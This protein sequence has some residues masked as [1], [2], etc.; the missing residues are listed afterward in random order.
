MRIGPEQVAQLRAEGAALDA[1]E[2][3]VADHM[4][5][6]GFS[7]NE[8]VEAYRAYREL[9]VR[10]PEIAGYPL[11]GIETTAIALRLRLRVGARHE[12]LAAH[13]DE[14]LPVTEAYNERV[15]GGPRVVT[16]G[17]VLLVSGLVMIPAGTGIIFWGNGIDCSSSG[18]CRTRADWALIPGALL[19]AL[20]AGSLLSAIICLPVGYARKNRWVPDGALDGDGPPR[21]RAEAQAPALQLVYVS[22]VVTDRFAGLG[23][24]FSF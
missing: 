2:A 18:G 4:A 1:K 19:N 7:P 22:P 23:A 15:V 17:W 8:Y 3:A 5:A 24:S 10:Y 20:G 21:T 16:A 14:K 13:F 9:K 12:L 11:E 6:R